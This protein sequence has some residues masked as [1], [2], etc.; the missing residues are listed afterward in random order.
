MTESAGPIS[1]MLE[2]SAQWVDWELTAMND[3][4]KESTICFVVATDGNGSHKVSISFV[5]VPEYIAWT[6]LYTTE[7]VPC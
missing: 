4:M 6:L 1:P 5:I 2:T 3:D 7:M